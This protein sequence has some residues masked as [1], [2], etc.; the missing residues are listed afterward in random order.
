MTHRETKRCPISNSIQ[1]NR[2]VAVILPYFKVYNKAQ[3]LKQYNTLT[4]NNNHAEQ[5]GKGQST[6]LTELQKRSQEYTIRKC[7]DSLKNG[8]DKTGYLVGELN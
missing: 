2:Q 3:S 5:R 4:K 7:I 8:G 1:Q 6:W